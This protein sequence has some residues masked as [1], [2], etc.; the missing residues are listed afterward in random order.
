MMKPYK[1]RYKPMMVPTG[2]PEIEIDAALPTEELT[3]IYFTPT[4]NAMV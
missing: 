1:N 2:K 4:H 3:E